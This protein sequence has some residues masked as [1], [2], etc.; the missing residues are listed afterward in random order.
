MRLRDFFKKST[1]RKIKYLSPDG[2]PDIPDMVYVAKGIWLAQARKNEEKFTN[3]I[4]EN[5]KVYS[6][7]GDL[8]EEGI[9]PEQRE[10]SK[11]RG[12][13]IVF[14][15]DV[16]CVQLTTN[17]ITTWFK[18]NCATFVNR[19]MKNK[20]ITQLMIKNKILNQ[21]SDLG[22]SVGQFFKGHFVDLKTGKKYNEKSMSIELIGMPTDVLPLIATAICKHFE[23]QT[24]LVKDFN[25]GKFYLVDDK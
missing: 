3:H 17:I 15:T 13:I 10:L 2:K 8:L 20:N 24:A 1:I 5:T 21:K 7:S 9:S 11:Y 18:Q 19:L 16:N 22:F 12:G 23:Q 25:T 6:L 4:Q 14:S